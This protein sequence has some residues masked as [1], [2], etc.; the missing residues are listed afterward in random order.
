MIRGLALSALALAGCA[1]VPPVSGGAD[2]ACDVTVVFGSYAMGV[3]HQLKVE[4]QNIIDGDAGVASVVETPWGRE[5]ES[6]LCI[7][8]SSAAAADRL[9]AVIADL[10]PEHSNRAPTSVT[11]RDSRTDQSI[12]PD[13]R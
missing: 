8:T 3:D 7:H 11:H 10:I 6:N 12:W 1:T 5:G 9:Y 4:I 2:D 13:A